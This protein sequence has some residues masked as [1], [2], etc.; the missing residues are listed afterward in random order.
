MSQARRLP[1]L[2]ALLIA[3]VLLGGACTRDRPKETVEA[4]TPAATP[5]PSGE[6]TPLVVTPTPTATP[7]PG[8]VP[9]P[10]PIVPIEPTLPPTPTPVPTE[11]PAAQGE[12]WHYYTVRD[13]DT[14]S[15][16][17][18]QFDTTVEDLQRL[19]DLS[20]TTIYVGQKLK[21]PGPASAEEVQ[22]VE[23]VVQPGDTLFSIA[24]RFGVDMQ[25]LASAN[26]ITDPSTIYVGQRLVIPGAAETPARELYKVQPGDTLSSIAQRFGVSL[27]D[28]MTANGITDPD[29]IYVGQVLRIP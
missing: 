28:L 11:P 13:G 4:W 18:V 25:E 5:V 15:S 27:Q 20:D 22:G 24:K 7:L 17:A 2:I 3:V 26:N 1:A 19:N 9:T 21:V 23:Y 12:N 14:L 29:A 6:E 16:I 8:V 10:V